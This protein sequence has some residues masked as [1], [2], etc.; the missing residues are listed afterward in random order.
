M[1]RRIPLVTKEDAGYAAHLEKTLCDEPYFFF[2]DVR[3]R[4]TEPKPTLDI[5]A[6]IPK[7]VVARDAIEA[8]IMSAVEAEH[9]V[10]R[11]TDVQD[12]FETKIQVRSGS[13]GAAAQGNP[14][15]REPGGAPE[16]LGS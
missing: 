2:V 8:V 3:V 9:L 14:Q 15:V 11:G 4:P 16:V 12:H 6:G 10:L 1:S 5:V 13:L 7:R